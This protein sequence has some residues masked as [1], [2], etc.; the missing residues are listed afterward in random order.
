ML[1]VWIYSLV[2]VLI[3]ALISLFGILTLSIREKLLQKLLFI[4]VSFSA[5][6]LLGTAFIH[7]LPEVIN[8]AGFNL[9]ISL[10]LLSG[11]LLFFVLEKFIFW[12]HCHIPPSSHH[13]HP[14]AFT[15]LIGD[16]LHN[17]I[18]GMVIAG[19]YLLNIQAGFATTIAVIIHE[20]PQEI[21][22]FGV[23]VHGGFDR[24]KALFFN[25][26]TALTALLGA[27]IVLVLGIYVKNLTLF[28]IPFTAGGFIYIAGSD[29]IPELHKETRPKQS[30][31]QFI[32][33]VLGILITLLLIVIE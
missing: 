27:I 23:L 24:K 15:N 9:T 17:F 21:G 11:V 20:I 8:Q 28:L 30:F 18:D 1:S 22:D 10:Y 7:L 5:G 25:F 6:V 14:F 31:V 29:L 3:V 2:S 4:S 26:L 32:S 12:R 13:L 33:L 19:A 16:G